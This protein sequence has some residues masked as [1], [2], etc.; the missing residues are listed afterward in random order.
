MSDSKAGPGACPKAA[1]ICLDYF[2]LTTEG[3]VLIFFY[4]IYINININNNNSLYFQRVTHLAKKKLIFHEALYKI[5]P[6]NDTSIR[7]KDDL[8]VY[9]II[10][11]AWNTFKP[12]YTQAHFIIPPM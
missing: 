9:K 6:K 3:I 8:H 4:M 10:Q 2:S 11:A 1:K 12:T 7:Y 5:R